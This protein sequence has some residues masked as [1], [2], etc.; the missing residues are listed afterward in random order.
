M[1]PFL[2]LPILVPETVVLVGAKCPGGETPS[3][4]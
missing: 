1:C 4:K 2:I 3:W